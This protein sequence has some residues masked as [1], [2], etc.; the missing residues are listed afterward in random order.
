MTKFSGKKLFHHE[1]LSRQVAE[2]RNLLHVIEL[3][4]AF[5]EN[6]NRP[7][8]DVYE[9]TDGI[10]MEFDLPGFR[11]EDI[12]LTLTGSI[13]VLEAYRPR[14]PHNANARFVCLERRVGKFNYVVNIPG[15]I[16]PA[17][18]TAEYRLGVLRVRCPKL[19]NRQIP[20]T[21]S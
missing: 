18:I 3:R 16:N 6:E 21:E 13:L 14:S 5:D 2:I 8:M 4:D 1:V 17:A 12:T 10:I 15:T 20:I 19:L 7:P 9:T 11:I